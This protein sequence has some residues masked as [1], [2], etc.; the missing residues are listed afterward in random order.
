MQGLSLKVLTV[1]AAL[2]LS[3]L[4]LSAQVQADK[5]DAPL[6]SQAKVSGKAISGVIIPQIDPIVLAG[7]AHLNLD[8]ATRARYRYQNGSWLYQTEEGK[9][10]ID[11]NGTWVP[12]D[13]MQ[14]VSSGTAS[15]N[16][17]NSDCECTYTPQVQNYTSYGTYSH[18]HHHHEFGGIHYG[19]QGTGF[20]NGFK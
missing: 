3:P 4:L 14:N 17:G 18:R 12:Y 15:T 2:G 13:P 1:A 20:R 11:Q 6:K 8:D 5:S 7:T 10:L 16:L 19:H 9:W